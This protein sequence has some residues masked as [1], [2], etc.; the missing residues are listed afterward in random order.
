M[1]T[2]FYS[3]EDLL[4]LRYNVKTL[5]KLLYAPSEIICCTQ[6]TYGKKKIKWRGARGGIRNRLKHRGNRFPLPTL[7]LTNARSLQNIMLELTALVKYNRD[8]NRANLICI[9][10]TWLTETTDDINLDGYSLIHLDRDSVKSTKAIG[11]GLCMFVN[12]R[13]AKNITVRETHCSAHYELL[14]VSFRP[15]CLPREFVQITVILVYVPGPNFALAAEGIAASYNRAL[16]NSASDPVFLLGYFNKCDVSTLL[17]NL[18]QYITCPMRLVKTLDKCFGNVEGAY[19]PRLH[20]PLGR[21]D[22]NVIHLFIGN[23]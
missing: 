10:E 19:V 12:S 15:Y 8:F 11:G 20:P 13:W 9:T 7:I 5:P 4:R 3:R 21:S 2:M 22:H 16:C 6:T 23:Y 18:E 17:P 14:T 1:R